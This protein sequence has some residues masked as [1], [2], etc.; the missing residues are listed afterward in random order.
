[1]LLACKFLCPHFQY[2]W[3]YLTLCNQ[4]ILAGMFLP[5]CLSVSFENI[6]YILI[7]ECKW[8]ILTIS[9]LVMFDLSSI[10]SSTL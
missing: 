7:L 9:L 10:F 8:C 6:H 5:H 2:F 3:I 4:F 1:M